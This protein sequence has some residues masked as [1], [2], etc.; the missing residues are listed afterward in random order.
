MPGFETC[1]PWYMKQ[2]TVMALTLSCLA[3]ASCGKKPVEVSSG[4]ATMA[5]APAPVP[6]PAPAPTPAAKAQTSEAQEELAKKQALMD[7]ATMEDKYLNDP[8]AQ[9]AIGAQASSIYG[10]GDGKPSDSYFPK[11]AAGPVDG[12]Y[13]SNNHSDLG[14]DWLELSFAKPVSAT[15]VRI[16]FPD[17]KGAE[18]VNKLELQDTDG[19][20]NTVWAG[21]SDVKRDDRGRRTWFVRSFKK[22]PYKVKAVKFT[23]ANNVQQGYKEVDAVQLV[24]D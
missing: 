13:W 12:S 1:S 21:I 2:L 20:W 9:W 7:Y 10:E 18:A 24:G 5:P 11:S 4:P 19:K 14:F 16:V 15:E 8:R 3:L 6:T 17:G 22:T 23:I